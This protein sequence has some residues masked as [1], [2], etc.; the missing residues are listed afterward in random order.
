MLDNNV[1]TK[2]DFTKLILRIY[3][4]TEENRT[5]ALELVNLMKE[6]MKKNDGDLMV[7]SQ[8]ADKYFEQV[9]KQTEQLVKLSSV[10]QRFLS[11]EPVDTPKEEKEDPNK[12]FQKAINDL[13]EENKTKK[14]KNNNDSSRL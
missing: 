9:T 10:F 2:S 3:K 14:V 12:F 8:M 11:E 6:K 1:I 7:L 13:D 4:E 5:S